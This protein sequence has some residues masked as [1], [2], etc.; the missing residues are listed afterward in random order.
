M[1]RG[2]LRPEDEPKPAAP[3][4]AGRDE[5]DGDVLD[6]PGTEEA[7]A[8]AAEEDAEDKAPTL[9]ATLAAELRA[10]RTLG[11]QAELAGRPD[12]A[13]RVLLHALAG[14]AFY[15]RHGD[16]V[17]SFPAHPPAFAGVAGL[18]DSPVRRRVEEAEAEQRARLPAER[19]GLWE[20]LSGQDEAALLR[21]LAV[22]VA[23]V[24]DAGA[25]DWTAPGDTV[26]AGVAAAAGL[27][28][29]RRWSATPASYLTRVPKAAILAAVREGAARRLAGMRKEPMAEA[30]AAALRV[31]DAVAANDAAA[32]PALA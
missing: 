11:L 18:A 16:A 7:G 6:S 29:R 20:W 27:D 1:A 23:R 22:L 13:L 5:E 3:H 9:T 17:A 4:G 30:A 14:D 10:H 8:P 25:G 2:L 31:P 21:L 12:L 28:M 32:P 26:A 15:G 19:R 24:V